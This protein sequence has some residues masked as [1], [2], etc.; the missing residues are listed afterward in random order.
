MGSEAGESR[1]RLGLTV[2]SESGVRPSVTRV[3]L[4]VV[5]LPTYLL[6]GLQAEQSSPLWIGPRVTH[7]DKAS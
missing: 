6:L 5:K 7:L 1:K 2:Q 3:I 4:H